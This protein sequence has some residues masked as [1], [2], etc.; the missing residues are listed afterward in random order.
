MASEP[1]PPKEAPR[2]ITEFLS[3]RIVRLH[4]AL[5]A[6]AASVLD[7][8][9]GLSLGQ[10]RIMA[11]V[12]S[13]TA[14]TAR[15]IARKSILDPAAISRAVRSLEQDGLL[16]SSR[17]DADRR[18]V[19][20]TL[21]PAGFQTF[22]NTLPRMQARQDALLDALDPGERDAVFGILEKLENAAGR[23]EFNP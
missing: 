1:A 21:T 5:N 6:Q 12:G 9:A 19:T 22:E 20:L 2:E 4:H 7:R 23:R 8:V 13:G 14:R 15:D 11:M 18:V 17:T 16:T 10:W 3:Y